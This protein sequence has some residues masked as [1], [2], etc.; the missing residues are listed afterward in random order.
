MFS[1]RDFSIPPV[2]GS[3]TRYMQTG[4]ET[5]KWKYSLHPNPIIPPHHPLES[6][7]MKSRQ[8]CRNPF[9]SKKMTFRPRHSFLYTQSFPC[10]SQMFS[11]DLPIPSSL[12]NFSIFGILEYAF[13]CQM[14]R[15]CFPKQRVE[16]AMWSFECMDWF[17]ERGGRSWIQLGLFAKISNVESRMSL[18]FDCG[19]LFRRQP[20]FHTFSEE[21]WWTWHRGEL[22]S[23]NH[24]VTG[25]R[26]HFR[27]CI[28]YCFT[29]N[30]YKSYYHYHNQ[31]S[32][33]KWDNN[34][35]T[36]EAVQVAQRQR[37]DDHSFVRWLATWQKVF[38]HFYIHKL[39][40]YNSPDPYLYR[41]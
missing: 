41:E 28:A 27:G 17:Q 15:V 13:E 39:I 10:P 5:R 26:Q 32:L 8:G 22:I 40:P 34:P 25:M 24:K 7:L 2:I 18:R 36:L 38:V 33:L 14:R 9:G 6:A 16:M 29:N 20:H 1:G 4:R 19:W 31:R 35:T 37:N 23:N 30:R 21:Q 11:M 12:C 3:V